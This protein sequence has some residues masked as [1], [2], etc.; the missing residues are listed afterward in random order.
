MEYLPCCSIVPYLNN[1]GSF[2]SD[3]AISIFQEC[4]SALSVLH[5]HGFIHG[6]SLREWSHGIERQTKQP[7]SHRR[8]SCEA[9]RLRAGGFRG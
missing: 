4:L 3:E 2:C 1:I 8:G 6:V 9:Q 7:L 5:E